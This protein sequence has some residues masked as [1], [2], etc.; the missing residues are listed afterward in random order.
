M[1]LN[2]PN[3]GSIFIHGIQ[4][5]RQVGGQVIKGTYLVLPVSQNVFG[6]EC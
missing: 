3:E 5:C 1:I 2:C 6:V 4:L